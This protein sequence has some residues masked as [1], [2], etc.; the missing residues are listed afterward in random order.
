[1]T[2]DKTY[3]KG[4]KSVYVNIAVKLS[5]IHMAQL[6]GKKKFVIL[7]VTTPLRRSIHTYRAK[8]NMNFT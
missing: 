6:H 8:N 5:P 7:D 3:R 4:R 2:A 1:V